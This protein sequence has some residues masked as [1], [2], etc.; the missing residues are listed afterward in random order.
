VG[1]FAASVA[2]PLRADVHRLH[3]RSSADPSRRQ[4]ERCSSVQLVRWMWSTVAGQRDAVRRV[5]AEEEPASPPVL[6][7][8]S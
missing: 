1:V 4:R 6:T 3:E 2:A 8:D 7:R 5:R